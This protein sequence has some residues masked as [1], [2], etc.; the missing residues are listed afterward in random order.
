METRTVNN[1]IIC[2]LRVYLPPIGKNSG[3]SANSGFL[4]DPKH[5]RG[6]CKNYSRAA[7]GSCRDS[8][9]TPSYYVFFFPLR[10]FCLLIHGLRVLSRRRWGL[11]VEFRVG[12]QVVPLILEIQH[13]PR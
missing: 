9:R 11:H 10:G 13:D 3:V 6:L 2:V 7:L 1:P 5:I 4:E 12:F 8:L